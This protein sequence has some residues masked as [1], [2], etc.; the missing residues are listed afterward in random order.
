MRAQRPVLAQRY[1][2]HLPLDLGDVTPRFVGTDVSTGQTVVVAF[3]DQ[4]QARLASQGIGA[5]QRH[6]AGLVDSVASPQADAFPNLG[7][8]PP[9]GTALVAELIRGRTLAEVVGVEPLI[10]DRA[11]AWT[12]RILEGLQALH[13]RQ[14]PHG[15]LS[16]HA[17]VAEPKQRPI[18]PVVSQL[19]VPPLKDYASP[20]RLNGSGPT[21]A[22]D[23]WA[24]GLLLFEMLTGRLPFHA[25]ATTWGRCE[26]TAS[27]SQLLR[28]L[29]HGRELEVIVK[30]VLTS[31]RN[32]RTGSAEELLDMLDR[33]EQRIALPLTVAR[34]AARA[35][36]IS[37]AGQPA[38]WD[39]LVTD[40]DGGGKRLEA[41]LDAAEQMRQSVLPDRSPH[42]TTA[43]Q[44]N[45]SGSSGRLRLGPKGA[46]KSNRPGPDE[47]RRRMPSFG[48][49]MVAFR[50]RSRPRIGK[51]LVVAAVLGVFG[52]AGAYLLGQRDDKVR[53]APS[54]SISQTVDSV[55]V[56]SSVPERPKLTVRQ[57]RSQ[58]IRSYYRPESIAEGT[59]L[60]FVC[61]EEDFLVVNRRL[62]EEAL[63]AVPALG[64]AGVAGAGAAETGSV[65]GSSRANATMVI[66]SGALTKGWQLGWYELVATAIIRQ[67]CC[68]EAAPIKLP[69]STGWCQQL[70]TVVR[71]IAAD[72]V[73][74]GDIS[75]GVRTF[76]EAITCLMA[77]GRHVVYPYKA[78]P[79]SFQKAAFQQ[80]LKH[81]AEVDARRTARR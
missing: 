53:V 18:A 40:F 65:K 19:I 8:K 2:I 24:V 63:V 13:Q 29:S 27:D 76:D 7:E 81:A 16:S 44:S 3:A 26:L 54:S 57:E 73:K 46:S 11:V 1:A 43:P 58:C 39:R 30:R 74:V 68:S 25:D 42:T 69:E 49:E 33:W 4:E 45:R 38:P 48:P 28:S 9:S 6:L 50:E 61:T 35:T 70:Q 17:I 31:D 20:E 80:F 56:S 67:N 22:D 32:R 79:T 23:L 78:A 41:T 60:G 75:P 64:Q 66:R 59:D 72:S 15:A 37:R 5:L 10:S 47:A 71:R 62:N 36:P 21:I 77:Q 55:A 14:V 52:A 51:W 34:A 12:I